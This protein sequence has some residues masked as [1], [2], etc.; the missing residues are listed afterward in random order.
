MN[1]SQA[2]V[3]SYNLNSFEIEKSEGVS[4]PWRKNANGML[5]YTSEGTMSVSIN[6]EKDRSD[7]QESETLLFYAGT[8]EVRDQNIIVHHVTNASGLDRIGKEMVREASV[9]GNRIRL[10]SRGEFGVATLVWEKRE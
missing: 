1:L 10:I 3:G 8:Y 7:R 4:V 2:I 6:A 9:E 5:I